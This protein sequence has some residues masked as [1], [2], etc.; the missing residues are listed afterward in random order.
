VLEG[1]EKN[2]AYQEFDLLALRSKINHW[3]RGARLGDFQLTAPAR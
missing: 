3:M 1:V 2:A